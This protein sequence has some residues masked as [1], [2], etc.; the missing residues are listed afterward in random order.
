MPDLRAGLLLG[1]LLNRHPHCMS[2][3]N[4]ILH[5]TD[6]H[7]YLLR[8]GLFS[9]VFTVELSEMECRCILSL[10][11]VIFKCLLL[12]DSNAWAC[13]FIIYEMMNL[14]NYYYL[15]NWYFDDGILAPQL[16]L[17]PQYSLKLKVYTGLTSSLSHRF[18]Q[19]IVIGTSIFVHFKQTPSPNTYWPMR[20]YRQIK[21]ILFIIWLE[22]GGVFSESHNLGS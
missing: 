9:H 15:L 16:V 3:S 1:H 14:L 21:S 17:K 8:N 6:I 13:G 11:E 5:V 10:K 2:I 18:K 7:T 4:S 19:C 20:K 12:R 22:I